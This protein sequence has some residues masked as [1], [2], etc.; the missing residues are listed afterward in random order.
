[1]AFGFQLSA[2]CILQTTYHYKNIK[3]LCAYVPVAY[4]PTKNTTTLCLCAC[5]L[6]AYKKQNH[7]VPL[8]LL[9]LY[10]FQQ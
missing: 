8:C 2:K 3:S 5:C 9:P 10:L 7:S 1:M 6:C 4:V